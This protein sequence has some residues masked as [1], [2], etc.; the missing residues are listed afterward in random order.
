M[1]EAISSGHGTTVKVGQN[2][3]AL[4]AKSNNG[5][6][7]WALCWYVGKKRHTKESSDPEVVL[8]KASEV[9]AAFEAGKIAVAALGEARLSEYVAADVALPGVSLMDLVAFYEKHNEGKSGSAKFSDVMAAHR[10]SILAKGKETRH[11][12]TVK[13]HYARLEKK[14]GQ[15]PIGLVTVRDLDEY[16]EGIPNLKTR[17][18]H[19]ISL[20]SLFNFAK[21]KGQLP[22]DRPT[23]AEQTDRPKPAQKDV[24]VFTPEE[25]KT[26]LDASSGKLRVF[27]LLGMFAG[28]RTAEIHRLQ[29]KYIPE[30]CVKLPSDITKTARR[31]VAEMPENLLR[32]LAPL[33]GKPEEHVTFRSPTYLYK[34]LKKLCKETGVQWKDNAPRHSFVSYHL[35]L[36]RD[37]SRTSK[38]A[39]HS[40]R[41]LETVYLKLV[42]RKDAEA[43]FNVNPGDEPPTTKED[44]AEPNGPSQNPA[45]IRGMGGCPPPDR[46]LCPPEQPHAECGA[47]SGDPEL[48]KSA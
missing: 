24:Q 23:A 48:R 2:K 39:G 12:N 16:L 36:H 35:E 15:S 1:A 47:E 5:R 21:R 9:L 28:I 34:L 32:W 14:F 46:G 40:L 29:W 10:A 8:A 27:L 4:Y 44:N 41:M 11:I 38:A 18:N 17:L 13:N 37:P 7:V 25:A 19:R 33:R 30:D 20:I 22:Y 26:L 3:V 42:S 6:S 31:R 45:D 43:W